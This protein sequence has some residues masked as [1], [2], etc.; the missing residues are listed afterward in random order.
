[1]AEL[2]HGSNKLRADSSFHPELLE[3]LVGSEFSNQVLKGLSKMTLVTSDHGANSSLPVSHVRCDFK[4]YAF[5]SSVNIQGLPCLSVSSRM[6]LL[7][8]Y[9]YL[10]NAAIV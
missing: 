6:F 5:P 3:E 2:S 8:E 10:R 4:K 1:M 7:G 9:V